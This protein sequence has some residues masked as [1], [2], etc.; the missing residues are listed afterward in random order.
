MRLNSQISNVPHLTHVPT[1]LAVDI[2]LDTT[3]IIWFQ[4]VGQA[5]NIIDF[6]EVSNLPLDHYINVIKSKPYI[7]G[8]CV[9]P[10]DFANRE[11]S[12]GISRL[13]TAKNF[14][15]KFTIAPNISIADGIEAV[16][17]M[18]PRVWV[19]HTAYSK[20]VRH[21]ELYSQ[22]FC[23]K[24]KIYLGYPNHDAHSHA[25][26]V[27]E[28]LVLTRNGNRPINTLQENDEA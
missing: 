25:C 23:E 15:L 12:S 11:Y 14:G 2:G 24:R 13:E 8:K 10:H 27:G 9:A 6:Y 19:D 20:L 16:R 26:L 1:N 3:A 4:L 17:A 5:I 28:T 22:K 21:I 18:L 7:L